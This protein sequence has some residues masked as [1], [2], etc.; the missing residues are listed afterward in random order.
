MRQLSVARTAVVLRELVAAGAPPVPADQEGVPGL[1]PE[2]WEVLREAATAWPQRWSQLAHPRYHAT[3]KAAARALLLAEHRGFS[4]PAAGSG[5]SKSG[6]S[7]DDSSSSSA[8]G[9]LAPPQ[10]HG[11]QLQ[12][13]QHDCAQQER[14]DCAQQQELPE[15]VYHLPPLGVQHIIQRMAARQSD[16]VRAF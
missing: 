3:F 8:G 1:A 10:A 9:G 11:Q 6:S 7:G 16:W 13:Q 12:P 15:V 14:Q 4:V 2:V 5:T